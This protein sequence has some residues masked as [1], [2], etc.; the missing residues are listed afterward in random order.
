MTIAE[1]IDQAIALEAEVKSRK[2]QLEEVKAELQ[3]ELYTDML[4]KNKKWMQAAGGKGLCNLSVKNK[5]EVDNAELLRELLGSVTD[6]KL[7]RRESVDYEVETNFKKALI[8]LYQGDYAKGD[9]PALLTQLG[10]DDKQI[11]VAVKKLSG[12]YAKDQALLAGF[13]VT[14]ALEEELDLI[15]GQKNYELVSRYFDTDVIDEA[16]L[17]KLK[18]AL[19][20][21]DTLAIGFTALE[22]AGESRKDEFV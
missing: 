18:L 8:A 13:G 20:V 19:S 16:F 7:T 2:K 15:H 3:S 21:E 9:I 1:R 4:N 14:G 12:D 6:G 5:L 10:L 17:K 22:T 11:K